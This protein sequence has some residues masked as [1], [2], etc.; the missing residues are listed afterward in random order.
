MASLKTSTASIGSIKLNT[1]RL[2]CK[3][4]IG[5]GVPVRVAGQKG[6]TLRNVR[7]EVGQDVEKKTAALEAL[8]QFKISADR[9]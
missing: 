6:L 7:C 3:G 2:R 8:E 9:E 4:S 5:I 1:P